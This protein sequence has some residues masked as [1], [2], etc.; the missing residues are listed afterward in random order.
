MTDDNVPVLADFGLATLVENDP[1]LS[2]THEMITSTTTASLR[3][4]PRWMAPELLMIDSQ[5]SNNETDVWAFGCFILVCIVHHRI[6]SLF[7]IESDVG[8]DHAGGALCDLQD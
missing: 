2:P 5:K 6:V 7:L 1:S 4:T 8:T 3:G